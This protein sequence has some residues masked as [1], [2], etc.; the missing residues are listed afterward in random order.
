MKPFPAIARWAG[1]VRFDAV[2]MTIF[3][4]ACLV[5]ALRAW[6]A[7]HPQHD[8]WAPLNLNDPPGWATPRKLAAMR[9]DP[10][11]CRAVLDRSNVAFTALDPAG[12]AECRRDDRTVLPDVPLR[13][14][15]PAA[16]CAVGAGLAMWMRHAVDPA[17]R[18]MLGSPVAGVEHL[19]TY[20]CRRING[21]NSGVWSE[22]ATG[23]AI[24]IAAFVLADGTRI[25]VLDDW[26]D[27]EKGAFLRRVRD[28]AC[29]MFGTVLSPDYNAAHADHFHLDQ[30]E[31]QFGGVC[32]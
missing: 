9:A 23:N 28:G 15:G 12:D 30:A 14:A 25:S 20:S 31:R 2:A 10:A 16:T 22:H 17:A 26:G 11:E 27:A 21:G 18:D 29:G 19:G 5:L 3:V 6:L 8:P 24:D 1:M 32:R 13:P 7:D 4:A